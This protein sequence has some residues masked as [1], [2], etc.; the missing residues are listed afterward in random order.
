MKQ[1]ERIIKL[2]AG[3]KSIRKDRRRLAFLSV[4]VYAQPATLAK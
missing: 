1:K 3:H 4:Y 2:I